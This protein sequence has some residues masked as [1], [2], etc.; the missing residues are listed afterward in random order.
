MSGYPPAALYGLHRAALERRGARRSAY[1]ANVR[2]ATEIAWGTDISTLGLAV[3][4]ARPLEIGEIVRV[5]LSPS[6]SD[7]ALAE[8]GAPARVV[9]IDRVARGARVALQFL[10]SDQ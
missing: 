1:G 4:M 8:I 6:S 7:G 2:V 5:A 10:D 9:R 3:E